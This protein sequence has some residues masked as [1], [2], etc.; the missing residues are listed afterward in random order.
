MKKNKS[1]KKKLYRRDSYLVAPVDEFITFRSYIIIVFLS[2]GKNDIARTFC[3][4]PARALHRSHYHGVVRAPSYRAA[5]THRGTVLGVER[6]LLLAHAIGTEMLRSGADP[7]S[8]SH[9]LANGAL[10]GRGIVHLRAPLQ[11]EIQPRLEKK[12]HFFL[13][14]VFMVVL[15]K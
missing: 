10:G 14:L 4:R 9:F 13:L 6:Q 2:Y 1:A 5:P 15:T 11:L 12:I 8:D 7:G 3:V